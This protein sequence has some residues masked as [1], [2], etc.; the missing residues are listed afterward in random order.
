MPELINSIWPNSL[1]FPD[2]GA[3]A[4]GWGSEL[5]KVTSQGNMESEW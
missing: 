1:S 4:Q 3:K 5:S 2:K